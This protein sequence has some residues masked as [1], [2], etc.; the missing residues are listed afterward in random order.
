MM[1]LNHEELIKQT[2]FDQIARD[3]Q[4][5]LTGTE[6]EID[7]KKKKENNNCR[8]L[9]TLLFNRS[10]DKLRM[11]LIQTG[12]I[13]A[14]LKIFATRDLETISDQQILAFYAFTHPYSIEVSQLMFSKKPYQPFLLK[15]GSESSPITSQHPHFEEIS[16]NGGIEKFFKLFQRNLNDKT[17]DFPKYKYNVITLMRKQMGEELQEQS[18]EDHDRR[19]ESIKDRL[20]VII[21]NL[22]CAQEVT[23]T[24]MKLQ[25]IEHL[26]SLANKPQDWIRTES[27]K[28]LK[29]L[30]QNSVN[31][32]EI[33]KG[34]FI[35]PE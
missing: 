2:Q 12:I 29:N 21:G 20:S 5:P 30:A 33:Q 19:T 27:R 13:D 32:T 9:F 7:K 31:R 26:K 4:L 8:Y 18:E 23:N 15:S 35:I 11:S 3:L 10:D 17:D 1:I 28:A 22:L 24:E 6:E 16:T 34:G 25:I 14:L